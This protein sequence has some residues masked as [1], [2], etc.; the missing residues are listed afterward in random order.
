MA[1][2][3]D[4]RLGVLEEARSAAHYELR[5]V[6]RQ[7]ERREDL[8]LGRRAGLNVAEL[9]LR[10]GARVHRAG[11]VKAGQE[12]SSEW[13]VLCVALE[14]WRNPKK[15]RRAAINAHRAAF[16]NARSTR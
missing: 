2:Q 1:V 7:V 10:A 11:S 14:E 6:R 5:R 12:G 3:P 16:R 15:E 8:E 4:A 13:F 9:E